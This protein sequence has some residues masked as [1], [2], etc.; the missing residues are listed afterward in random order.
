VDPSQEL[1]RRLGDT[2]TELRENAWRR[3]EQRQTNVLGGIEL[4]ETV[5]G[6]RSRCL[7]DFR[8]EL[9]SGCAGADDDDVDVRRPARS[10]PAVGA[11]ARGK[12]PAVKSLGVGRRVERNRVFGDAGNA[13]IVAGAADAEK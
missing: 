9:D 6:M 13:E 11:H 4:V 8:G 12:Q 10:S 3:L 7:A 2:L 5:A 1:R